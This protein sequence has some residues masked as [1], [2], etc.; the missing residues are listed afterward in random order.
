MTQS[1]RAQWRA[2]LNSRQSEGPQKIY[3]PVASTSARPSVPFV[4]ARPARQGQELGKDALAVEVYSQAVL[5]E[6]Q[7]RLNEATMLYRRAFRMDPDVE[8]RCAIRI[9]SV[10]SLTR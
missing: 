7:G 5:E 3:E 1:C 2:E 9:A 6:K 4:P 10:L 8:Q